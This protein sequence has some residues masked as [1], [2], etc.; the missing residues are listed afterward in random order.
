MVKKYQMIVTMMKNNMQQMQQPKSMNIL[1]FSCDVT[2]LSLF[3]LPS[4]VSACFSLP[5]SLSFILRTSSSILEVIFDPL[6]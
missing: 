2:P 1:R 5:D 4:A 6:A 3:S